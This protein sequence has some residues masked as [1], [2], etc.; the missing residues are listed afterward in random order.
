MRVQ[1]ENW[2]NNTVDPGG[3]DFA[4]YYVTLTGDL[5]LDGYAAFSRAT[6]TLNVSFELDDP[7]PTSQAVTLAIIDCQ[8]NIKSQHLISKKI[9]THSFAIEKGDRFNVLT[10]AVTG[11]VTRKYELL[12]DQSKAFRL[13]SI[14]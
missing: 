3:A 6:Q 13:D 8:G 2:P 9:G 11:T 14:R 1:G 5:L 4:D 12:K 7:G 10:T